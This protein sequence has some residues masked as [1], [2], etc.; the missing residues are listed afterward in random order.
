MHR[1]I[2]R[3]L[4]YLTDRLLP[5]AG[6]HRSDPKSP[7]QIQRGEH[8]VRL[9]RETQARRIDG[10]IPVEEANQCN[11]DDAH[12]RGPVLAGT[13]DFTSFRDAII[14]RPT[15]QGPQPVL[16]GCVLDGAV[17][18]GGELSN[19]Q[20]HASRLKSAHVLRTEIGELTLCD[21]RHARIEDTRIQGLAGCNLDGAH[22]VGCDLTGA[23]LRGS[24]FRRTKITDCRLDNVNAA[25]VVL[26]GVSGLNN[27]QLEKFV[28]GGGQTTWLLPRG[29][30]VLGVA[31]L[32]VYALTF[33]SAPPQPIPESLYPSTPNEQVLQ[34]TQG[35]L[36]RFRERLAHAHET[37]KASGAT[38]RTWPTIRDVQQNRYDMDGDGVGESWDLLAADGIPPNHLTQSDGGVLPF[39]KEDPSQQDIS[40]VETDWYYCELNGRLFAAAG[41]SN[42]ATLNW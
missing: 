27:A 39:C 4:Q 19:L 24:S 37:M 5:D 38:N 1:T 6:G 31:A 10:G 28:Q 2:V 8:G 3:T 34:A 14:E 22:L 9:F 40:N 17:I 11:Y 20:V 33:G 30:W 25:G 15:T 41:V 23:D 12:L 42:V 18:E 13:C 29:T 21:L 7:A 26:E 16:S 35:A 32:S 36:G